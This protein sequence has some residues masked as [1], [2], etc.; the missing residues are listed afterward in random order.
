MPVLSMREAYG[1]A[2]VEYGMRN[3]EV[4]VLDADTSSST[5][6]KYFQER[7]PGRFFNIGIAEPCMV[8]VAVGLALGGKIPFANAFAPLMATRA[9][10][11]I[12]TC[13]CYAQTNVKLVAGYAGVSDYKD[14]ATHHSIMDL[15]V[16]RS[17]PGIT[18]VV[19]ADDTE[20][21]EW[22][23][24]IGDHDGPVYFRLSREASP[25]IHNRTME[26]QI[27]KGFVLREGDDITIVTL[28]SMVE[29]SLLAAEALAD[30]GI[31]A[32]VLEI[33][34]LKPLDRALILEA[35][36]RTESLI[37][38]EEHSIIGGLGDAVAGLLAEEL[39]IPM[40]KVGIR[41][42]FTSTA[43]DH[44]SLMDASG[45]SV[46]EI[47]EAASRVMKRK[48]KSPTCAA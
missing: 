22:V 33:P 5:L 41:D 30:K 44:Q 38:A 6:T 23:P 31:G 48:E 19:A 34:T 29:R 46:G 37:T 39:P 8:D 20:A 18:I 16:M 28:G 12:R 9:L 32:R 26:L 3:P 11:Q 15:A 24:V 36:S 45:L 43:R 10:E 35:A 21:A 13:V 40:E 1:R 4:I 14:G 2:V 47:V 7:I 25:R 42:R 17:L 27:G